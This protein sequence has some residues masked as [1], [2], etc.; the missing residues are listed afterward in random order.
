MI[1]IIVNIKIDVQI[2]FATCSGVLG[3]FVSHAVVLPVKNI[4]RHDLRASTT[5]KTI[6][7]NTII[8]KIIFKESKNERFKNDRKRLVEKL[9][10]VCGNLTKT[11][12]W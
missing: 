10:L 11:T 12:G 9:F 3:F 1:F 4:A 7:N 2:S 6:E 5:L 8:F